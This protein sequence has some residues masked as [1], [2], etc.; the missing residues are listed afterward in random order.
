MKQTPMHNVYNADLLSVIPVDAKRVI[1]VGC[2]SGV[3]AKAYLALNPACEYIGME[4]DPLYAE[5]ARE[6]CRQVIVGNVEKM[7]DDV[8]K[9]HGAFDC[10]IF[11]DVL[12]HLYD[13]WAVL[14]RISQ[15][16][17][18]PGG[19]VVA[20]IPNMQHWS[21]QFALN[22]GNLQYQDMGLLDRTHIRWFTRKTTIQMFQEAG[23]HITKLGARIFDEP[24][25]EEH[26]PLIWDMAELCRVD[27]D[28]AV[29]DATPMQWIV[30]A[31][32]ATDVTAE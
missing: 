30:E 11:G 29:A 4:I 18:T 3:F 24:E 20:C 32:L 31:C 28:E 14:K 15:G 22:Q 5:V 27:P 9:T 2:S 25:R 10:W 19:T 16:L 17:L 6:H 12:E 21:I 13:P 1:E 23:L 7:L 8:Q 26:M